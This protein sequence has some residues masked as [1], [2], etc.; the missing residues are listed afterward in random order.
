MHCS[1]CGRADHNRKGHYRCQETIIQEGVEEVD[2]NYDNPSFLQVISVFNFNWT[3]LNLNS[4]KF[5][6]VNLTEFNWI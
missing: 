5:S 1:I 6:Y 4:V 2:E 3:S